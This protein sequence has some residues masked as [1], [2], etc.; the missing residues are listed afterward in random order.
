MPISPK[1]I[2]SFNEATHRFNIWVG[3]VRSGKTYSSILKFIDLLKFG[4]PGD[5]MIIGVNRSTIQR[6]ILTTLYK[7]LGFPC[8]SA[9]VNKTSLYG[10]DLYFVGAPDVS[11]VTTIQGS[12]LAIAYV[13]EATCIPL[14]FW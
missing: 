3:A 1:Q 9:M 11:A 6:N 8:P 10:R 2:L 4:P 13:D 14:P 5:A 7:I 12:T